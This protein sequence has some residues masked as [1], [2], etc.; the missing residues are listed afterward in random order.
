MSVT[1]THT[2]MPLSSSIYWY[3]RLSH[4]WRN[5]MV[6][7]TYLP[8]SKQPLSRSSFD[9]LCC[10]TQPRLREFSAK[11]RKQQ[12]HR[13]CSNRKNMRQITRPSVLFYM[14]NT[15]THTPPLFTLAPALVM[16]QKQHWCCVSPFTNTI[17]QCN[18]FVSSHP[19]PKLGC[20]H[21]Q[22]VVLLLSIIPP[23]SNSR[24]SKSTAS[25][26]SVQSYYVRL[27]SKGQTLTAGLHSK[28][29]DTSTLPVFTTRPSC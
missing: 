18:L 26:H 28:L 19:P 3:A 16:T 27:A 7:V 22:Y 20:P 9:P 11:I 4:R 25:V 14:H 10:A 6:H 13:R 21:C 24:R 2:Y 12:R 29:S 1:R 23:T 15:K 8:Q 17:I 5:L